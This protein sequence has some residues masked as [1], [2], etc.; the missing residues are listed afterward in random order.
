MQEIEKQ[1]E[2]DAIIPS[3]VCHLYSTTKLLFLISVAAAAAMHCNNP[4]P[5]TSS[6][7]PDHKIWN[8]LSD[9]ITR[10]LSSY[11]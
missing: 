3:Y 9:T 2:H 1:G 10:A 11:N 4:G 6:H 5:M 7:P 8:Y